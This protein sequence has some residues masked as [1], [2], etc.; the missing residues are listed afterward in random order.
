M[1]RGRVRQGTA[2]AGCRGCGVCCDLYGHTLHAD[3]DDLERWRLQGRD[4]V[5]RR[6]GQGGELWWAEDG[7]ARQDHCPFFSW[8]GAEGG[9]CAV[10]ATKPAECRAYPTELHG[11]R[12]VMGA[13]FPRG[14][15][16]RE[17]A[18]GAP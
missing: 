6:V 14:H 12:C 9:A 8:V 15:G 18:E 5:L 17:S 7:S 11:S 3:P 1:R 10:H 13:E 4:D 2:G 16:R